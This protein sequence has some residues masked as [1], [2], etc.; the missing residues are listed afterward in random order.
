MPEVYHCQFCQAPVPLADVNV[1]SDLALCR[2]CGKTMAFSEITAIHGAEEV[3]LQR[4]PKG[5]RIEDNA[6][7]GRSI[8]YRKIS[9]AVIFLLPFTAVWA[10]GSMFG[11]YGTQI[12]EG[13]FDLTRSLFGLPFLIGS[14]VLVSVVLFLLIGRWRIRYSQGLLEAALEIGPFGWTRRLVCDRSAR[15][16]IRSANWQN[17][18]TPQE[19]IEVECQGNTLRFGSPIPGEA[20]AFI[21]EA[22]RRTLAEG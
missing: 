15:V 6:I 20:K 16:N 21:A 22:L 7:R 11:I 19:L 5:V 14:V 4:P 12:K 9:P 13:Q 10:G 1:A 18:H 17:N 2:A 3:D 8:I